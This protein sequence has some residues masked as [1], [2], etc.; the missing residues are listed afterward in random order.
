[1]RVTLHRIGKTSGITRRMIQ[2]PIP[3][4]DS[5]PRHSHHTLRPLSPYQKTR[6]PSAP[7]RNSFRSRPHPRIQSSLVSPTPFRPLPF[8]TPLVLTYTS[9][10]SPPIV[11]IHEHRLYSRFAFRAR[12][13]PDSARLLLLV[14]RSRTTKSRRCSEKDRFERSRKC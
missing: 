6:L 14:H 8:A 12:L 13:N 9:T 10:P 2:K 5:T 1:M 11:V 4:I 3:A 7:Q